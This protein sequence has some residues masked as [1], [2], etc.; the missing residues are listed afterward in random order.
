M[1]THR[2]RR[3]ADPPPQDEDDYTTIGLESEWYGHAGSAT[4][5]DR[6]SM[7]QHLAMED[8][9]SPPFDANHDGRKANEADWHQQ[10]QVTADYAYGTYGQREPGHARS[11]PQPVAPHVSRDNDNRHDRGDHD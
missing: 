4:R 11:D 8:D 2:G 7:R 9:G 3:G 6:E 5:S 1:G 10:D